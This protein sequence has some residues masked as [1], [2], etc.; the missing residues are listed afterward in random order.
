MLLLPAKDLENL[1]LVGRGGFGNVYRGWS[2]TLKMEVALKVVQE[3]HSSNLKKLMKDLMKERDVMQ[4]ASNPHVLRLLGVYEKAEGSLVEHGLV[5]EYMPYGSLRTLFDDIPAVPWALRFQILH[6]VVLGMNYLHSLDPPIIHRDLKPCNVLLNKHLD[7]QITDFGL[8]KIIGATTSAMPSF[9]GTVSYMPP[10]ALKDIN[11]QPS[12]SYD[13]YSFGILAWTVFSGEEPYRGVPS[14]IILCCV[15]DG[16]RPAVHVLDKYRDVR[17]VP[18]VKELMVRCWDHN[19]ENRPGFHDCSECTSV[20]YEAHQKKVRSAVRSVEDRLTNMHSSN[21]AES[22]GYISGDAEEF[23]KALENGESQDSKQLDPKVSGEDPKP[24]TALETVGDTN[25]KEEDIPCTGD[26][27]DKLVEACRKSVVEARKES[28]V[29]ARKKSD[30]EAHKKSDVEA[31]KKSVVE[32]PKESVVEAPKKFDVEARKE[33]VVEALKKSDVE[34][35]KKSDVEAH[36][37][38]VVEARKES[39]AEALKK[40]DVEARKESVDYDNIKSRLSNEGVISKEDQRKIN[41]SKNLKDYD[42]TGKIMGKKL[43]EQSPQILP[44]LKRK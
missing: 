7:V 3:G 28:V 35:L 12:K 17:M 14:A 37:K 6:Q 20:M 10:E 18:E 9:E 39:V 44:V 38:S 4:K 8:S 32:A 29:E 22:S 26:P 1:K 21:Q 19:A 5:M 2:Q 25:K 36:K 31:H 27:M 42:T 41:S 24:L 30:V 34:A 16:Q 13:V 43:Q 15:I 33:S 23:L 11:Y 40:S